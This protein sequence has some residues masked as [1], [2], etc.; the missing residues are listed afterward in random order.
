VGHAEQRYHARRR[1]SPVGLI[2]GLR[3]VLIAAKKLIIIGFA[4]LG[5][6]VAKLLKGRSIPTDGEQA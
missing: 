1:P 4:A 2:A 6:L 3:K 5:G